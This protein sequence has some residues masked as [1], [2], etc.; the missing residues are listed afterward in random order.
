VPSIHFIERTGNSVSLVLE[1]SCVS[2]VINQSNFEKQKE[3][4]AYR[5]L[6]LAKHP[7]YSKTAPQV[8]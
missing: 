6:I 5:A 8:R 7:I 1:N 4:S 2:T 3:A